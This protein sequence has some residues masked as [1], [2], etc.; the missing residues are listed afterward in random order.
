[1]RNSLVLPNLRLEFL[2]RSA[3]QRRQRWTPNSFPRILSINLRVP[4]ETYPCKLAYSNAESNDSHTA[5]NS[6]H[7]A[8]RHAP[9]ITPN[10]SNLPD[11]CI[12]IEGGKIHYVEEGSGQAVILL[13]G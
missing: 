5:L 3:C 11:K 7:T 1:M 10:D 6:S 2:L 8:S 12:T 4:R 9:A 13:H